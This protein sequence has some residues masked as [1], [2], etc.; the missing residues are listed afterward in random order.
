MQSNPWQVEHSRLRAPREDREALVEPSFDQVPALVE[1][2]LRI[3]DQYTCD[4]HGRRLAQLSQVARIELLTAARQWTSAYRNV[5]SE[6]TEA[7][8]LVYLAG[9]QPQMF[10]PGVW[11]KNFALGEL[12]RRHKATAV[13]L[14]VDG[15]V[16]SQTALRVPGGSVAEPHAEQ[17]PYD[18][19][20]PKIPY[21]DRRIEDRGLFA[22][23][24]ER[25]AER[26]APLVADPLIAQYW[27]LV[28][29]QA[30]HTDK[31]GVCLARARHMLESQWG[32]ETLEVPQSSV[33]SGE[34]FQWFAAHILAQLPE[35]RAIHNEAVLWYRRA[36]RVRSTSHPVPELA[37]KD[38]WL[39]APFWVWTSEQPQRRRLFARRAGGEIVLTDRHAWETRL[40][41]RADGE[42]APVADRLLELQRTGVRIR[43][44]ALLTTL[45]ARLALGDLF[46]H[47]I[48]GAKYDQVTDR[49]IERFWGVPAPWFMVLS[50]TLLL[51]IERHRARPEDLRAIR[52]QLRDMAYHPERHLDGADGE[53]A[54]LVRTKRR[55]AETPQTAENARHRCHTI[56]ETNALLQPWLEPQRQE[57]IRREIEVE[58][59][60]D[61]ERLLAWREYAFCLYP[62]STLR[63]FLSGLLHKTV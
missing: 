61:A 15:D 58:R 55:W 17:I 19:P 46:I 10:H 2:N 39:E 5:P 45:W 4:L 37:E 3:R 11:L 18:R 22:T 33:C 32:S 26:M 20:D 24:G 43:S 44:R 34:A 8:G 25:V 51:P 23:F 12:A 42:L 6:Q 21:E 56:R 54:D 48:G 40:P 1:D 62:E 29:D 59:S 38:S 28:L 49:L 50:A 53:A 57:M 35:F 30:D 7:S 60:L 14:I 16:T 52:G 63:G 36:H 27:P 41:Y 9:H 13:N 47:G 31:L